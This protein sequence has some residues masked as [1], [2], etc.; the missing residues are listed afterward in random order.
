[1]VV[2]IT[3][4]LFGGVNYVKNVYLFDS[5]SNSTRLI[6]T[7][8]RYSTNSGIVTSAKMHVRVSGIPITNLYTSY[9]MSWCY[10]SCAIVGEP[11]T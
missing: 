7:T 10:F 9:A 6:N 11:I 5:I 4:T 8:G 2:I 1:M 3:P